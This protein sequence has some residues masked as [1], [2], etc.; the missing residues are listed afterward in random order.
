MAL[1]ASVGYMPLTHIATPHAPLTRIATSSRMVVK[2]HG[3]EYV[4]WPLPH[5]L[6]AAAALTVAISPM[7][8]AVPSDL[9]L[10]DFESESLVSDGLKT[11]GM[12]GDLRMIKLWARL[13]AGAL[14]TEGREAA[15]Q[16]CEQCIPGRSTLIRSGVI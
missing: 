16:V 13:K 10:A 5:L 4:G 7:T 6:G 3:S 11:A 12:N 9:Q 15:A 8:A 1:F 2:D 14:E